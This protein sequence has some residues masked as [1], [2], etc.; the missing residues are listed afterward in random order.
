MK[1]ILKIT[2]LLIF[3]LTILPISGIQGAFG[4]TSMMNAPARHT[5][6]L[7]GK[8]QVIVDPL[9]SRNWKLSVETGNIKSL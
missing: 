3:E 1:K 8:W 9:E 6:S 5:K 2:L 4:Q 7:N